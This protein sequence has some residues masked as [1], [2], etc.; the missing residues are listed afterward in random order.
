MATPILTQ[1]SQQAN[2]GFAIT[3]SDTTDLLADAGNTNGYQWS[4]VFVA[5]ASGTVKVDLVVGGTVTL[6][7]V[8]GTVLGGDMPVLVKRVYATGTAAVSLIALNGSGGYL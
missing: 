8:Q 4:Y 5:G 2:A 1:P 6:Y 7:G 3:P